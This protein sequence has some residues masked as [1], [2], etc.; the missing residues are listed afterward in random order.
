[1]PSTK[2]AV[3]KTSAKKAKAVTAVDKKAGLTTKKPR[4]AKTVDADAAPVAKKTRSIRGSVRRVNAAQ[5]DK[6]LVLPKAPFE[7]I[8]R[9]ELEAMYPDDKQRITPAALN[10]MRRGTETWGLGWGW[11]AR[12]IAA[13]SGRTTMMKRD[14]VL[15]QKITTDGTIPIPS[16]EELKDEEEKEEVEPEEEAEE[17]SED[18]DVDDDD[19]DDDDDD[20]DE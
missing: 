12:D 19:D 7:K 17:E 6:R 4:K 10:M 15:C 2:T 9:G 13:H 20:A 11:R 18:E 14:L 1:M 8:V 3:P 16:L 5:K